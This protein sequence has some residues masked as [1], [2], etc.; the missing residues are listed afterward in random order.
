MAEENLIRTDHKVL[1]DNIKPKDRKVLESVG[2][3]PEFTTDEDALNP[4]LVTKL[5]EQKNFRQGEG[6]RPGR[7]TKSYRQNYGRIFSNS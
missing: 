1:R 2:I 4:D 7:V 5:W 3:D 6:W